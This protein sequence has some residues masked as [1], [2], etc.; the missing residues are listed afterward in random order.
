MLPPLPFPLPSPPFISGTEC[1]P[2]VPNSV[3]SLSTI[4]SV[5]CQRLPLVHQP[6][7]GVSGLIQPDAHLGQ[8]RKHAQS[9]RICP[10][11]TPELW[12]DTGSLPLPS[13]PHTHS[14]WYPL[15]MVPAKEAL[16]TQR[17]QTAQDS[18]C[19][20]SKIRL[21]F[22]LSLP[23]RPHTHSVC[24]QLLPCLSQLLTLTGFP[25]GRKFPRLCCPFPL[26]SDLCLFKGLS[27]LCP[28]RQ[29]LL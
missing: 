6:P 16:C 26:L 1:C 11:R 12:R 5:G 27:V 14:R 9:S 22:S 8:R 3:L 4:S 20:S 24:V 15:K 10:P 17:L 18:E 7:C 21:F 29:H 19:T 23:K 25:W 2:R 13:F 28:A